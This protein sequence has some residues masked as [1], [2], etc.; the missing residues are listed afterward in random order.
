MNLSVLLNSFLIKLMSHCSLNLLISLHLLLITCWN[1]NLLS[2]RRRCKGVSSK[3]LWQIKICCRRQY[4][5]GLKI[6]TQNLRLNHHRTLSMRSMQRFRQCHNW[7]KAF[8]YDFVMSLSVNL[9][10]SA[11][12]DCNLCFDKDREVL[13]CRQLSSLWWR[14]YC[15][16]LYWESW[17]VRIYMCDFL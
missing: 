10:F 15:W 4:C 5:R 2:N 1:C 8:G 11:S 3:S 6:C 12:K 16:Y 7:I 13:E 17:F 9:N 14:V